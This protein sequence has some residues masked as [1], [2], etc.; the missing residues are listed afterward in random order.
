MKLHAS[1][2]SRAGRA[3]VTT[4]ARELQR[5]TSSLLVLSM[6]LAG[7]IAMPAAHAAPISG[8][9]AAV[10]AQPSGAFWQDAKATRAK[11]SAKGAV[12][13]VQPRKYRATTLDRFG[14]TAFA[15]NAPM[16]RTAAAQLSPLTISLPHPDGGYQR[17]TVVESP[18][19]EQAL[20]D[21]HPEIKTYAGK[22]IDDPNASVRMDI[23]PLGFHASVR[24]PKGAWYIDPYFHLDD[25]LYASYHGRE[26]P[27]QHGPLSEAM[28]TEAHIALTRGFYHAGDAVEVRGFGFAPGATVNITV[29]NPETDTSSRQ[30]VSATADQDGTLSTSLV[31]DPSRNLGAYE[32]TASDG[33]TTATTAYHVVDES[34]SPTAATGTQLRNYRLALVTDPSYATFFGGSANVT[35]AKVTLVNRITQVYEDETSIRLTLVGNNDLLNLDTAAKMTGANGPCGG[36]ACFTTTQA[37]GCASSTLTRNRQVIGLLIGASNYDVGHIGFG[38]NGGGLASLGVVG[39]SAKAQG[40]TGVPT[41]VGDLFA[42][43]YVAHEIGHQFAGNH[44]FNGVTG[45]CTGGN[46]NAGTSVEPGSGS[47][48]MAYAGIC[49]TDNLQPHSDAY[50]S[51][52]SFD[53][54][55][56]YVSGAETSLNEVQMAALTNFNTNGQQFQL[57]Y[58]GNASAPIIRGTNFT[59]A[60][61]KAAIEAIAGWPAGGTVTV[62]SLTD[63]GFTLTFSGSLA[64]TNLPMLGLSGLGAG[65]YIGEITAGGLSTR[66]GH[67]ITATG[68]SAPALNVPPTYTIPVRTP[69][70]L[71]GSASDAEGDT[72]TYLW[73]QN[74]RGAGTGTG[75]LTNAKTNGPLFRQFGTIAAVSEADTVKYNSPGENF[76]ST[77]PTRVFPDLAQILVNNTNAET[78]ACPTASSPATSAQIDCYSEYLPTAAYVGFAGTNAS[79]ASLNFKLTVRDGRGGVNSASTQLVLAPAAGPF[80]VTWPNTALQLNSGT[81]YTVTW[82]VA[83]TDAAPV[84]TSQV[85]V[86]LSTDGGNTFPHV[87][88]AS[89]P[90]NGS[91]SVTLPVLAAD[92][93]RI[94]VEAIDNVFFDVSNADFSIKLYGDVNGDGS[95]SCADLSIVRASLGKRAGQP[96]FDPR[97][98]VNGDGVVDIRDM[99]AV[100]KNVPAANTCNR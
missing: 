21:K 20:A 87:L 100:S 79:P 55:T 52:R 63:T 22:G 66:R 76:V 75:L 82:N 86:S 80:L 9:S 7:T 69:F 25:S 37:A 71:T 74:D 56:T 13:A 19:M 81:A 5:H 4:A 53:E 59:T 29:R 3:P 6:A 64:G 84:S 17:F 62:S 46:R 67:T 34:Q 78:G 92:K 44:T 95:I 42:V 68:N 89:V 60:G 61:I 47:S 8:A 93:A 99:A 23:T 96:G 83:N 85:K 26:L 12:P 27:N 39:G 58:G 18:V 57:S 14:L 28:Q 97:A 77:N 49:G 11:V 70:A 38:L 65:N 2:S 16:E 73:E 72:I 40:C 33:R 94:K 54:I 48:I 41:P 90:N 24:S 91:A 30:T 36:S 98:D 35:A 50:W 43:D 51:Q 88:A 31:A 1:A 32:I 15:A 45:S 10:A